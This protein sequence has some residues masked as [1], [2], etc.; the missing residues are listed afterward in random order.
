MADSNLFAQQ[1][2]I[3]VVIYKKD[4][5]QVLIQLAPIFSCKLD[6]FVYDNGPQP[7]EP[8]SVRVTYHHD[9][10]NS[11]VSKAYNTAF[12]HA[13]RLE[14]KWM[15]LLDQDTHL[16]PTLL[17]SFA[18]AIALHTDVS[19]FCPV[20]TDTYGV[21]S[22]YQLI[23]G[24]SIR[25][26]N[27]S[28]G[29]HDLNK[30][31]LINSGTLIKTECFKQS[32]GFDERFPLDFS[33]VVFF[34]RLRRSCSKFVVVRA[35]CQHSLSLTEHTAN[36]HQVFERVKNYSKAAR[37]YQKVCDNFV[38]MSVPILTLCIKLSVRYRS[39]KFLKIAIGSA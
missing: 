24:K 16:P 8:G 6:I 28:A 35:S 7:Q 13:N 12:T 34:S 15:L 25:R 31:M 33:D 27:I 3:V 29:R 22:P 14:K 18:E 26:K 4:L 17:D 9:P 2:L 20:V 30:W 38:W 39:L 11:G 36:I 21:V 5:N 23:F 32:G 37:Q 19:I 1:L 10:F